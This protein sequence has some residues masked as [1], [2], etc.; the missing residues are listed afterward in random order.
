TS[1]WPID[2]AATMKLLDPFYS[3]LAGRQAKHQALASAR[4]HYMDA[5]LNNELAHPYFWAGLAYIGPP[6]GLPPAEV[7]LFWMYLLVPLLLCSIGLVL[8]KRSQ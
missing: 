3:G 5:Q 8:Y 7:P 6:E 1:R 4:N 2:E